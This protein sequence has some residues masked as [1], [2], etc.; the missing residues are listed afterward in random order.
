[1][2]TRFVSGRTRRPID[3]LWMEKETDYFVSYYNGTV[4]GVTCI[5]PSDGTH[6]VGRGDGKLYAIN[7]SK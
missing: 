2:R 3:K 7:P 4:E 1:M 6:Y 5:D